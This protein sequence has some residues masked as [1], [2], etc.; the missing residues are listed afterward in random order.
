MQV[1][2]W[3]CP[4]PPH[5]GT[6]IGQIRPTQR[7][8]VILHTLD[9]EK[10]NRT[11]RPAISPKLKGETSRCATFFNSK[12]SSAQTTSNATYELAQNSVIDPSPKPRIPNLQGERVSYLNHQRRL[13]V[14]GQELSKR[15]QQHTSVQSISC[16]TL[17][18]HDTRVCWHKQPQ[19]INLSNQAGVVTTVPT[20][21]SIVATILSTL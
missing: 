13:R 17:Q 1:V 5:L 9:A 4:P 10:S 15:S 14:P 21:R 19:D 2:V 7:S 12:S 18:A 16:N 3:C 6:K 8:Q 20:V 11:P